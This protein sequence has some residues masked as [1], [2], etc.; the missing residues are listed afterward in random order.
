MRFFELV[1]INRKLSSFLQ[2]MYLLWT[3][4][5]G[6]LSAASS[7]EDLGRLWRVLVYTLYRY[8]YR[9]YRS[10]YIIPAENLDLFT[11]ETALTTSW[12]DHVEVLNLV[13]SDSYSTDYV[14]KDVV[15]VLNH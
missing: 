13:A 5:T 4:F 8:L 3:L 10:W 9:E 15:F 6:D 2:V 12:T 11:P 7:P 14:G 1:V